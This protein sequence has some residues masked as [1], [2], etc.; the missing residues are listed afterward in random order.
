M[1]KINPGDKV[2]HK[3]FGTGVV[4]EVR[5]SGV[6]ARITVDFPSAVGRKKLL[7]SAGT[8]FPDSS[9]AS[10]SDAAT[11][12]AGAQF[13]EVFSAELRVRRGRSVNPERIR[14]ELREEL[15]KPQFW[16]AVRE[17]MRAKGSMPAVLDNP[18]GRVSVTPSGMLSL[19]ICVDHGIG[20]ARDS[21]SLTSFTI[22]RVL[23]DSVLRDFEQRPPT[24]AHV[25]YLERQSRIPKELDE[26]NLVQIVDPDLGP[27]PERAPLRSP[28]RVAPKGQI[29][30]MP[31]RRDDY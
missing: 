4:A 3:Q 9:S 12:V 21:Q 24:D 17:K 6:D 28:K 5:G 16:L 18:S 31:K 19:D 23:E 13:L 20:N 25:S 22:F 15:S 11:P 27:L 14:D 1:E 2:F 30:S 26:L 10:R 29:R 8:L 7:A